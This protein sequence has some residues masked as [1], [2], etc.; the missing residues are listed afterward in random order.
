MSWQCITLTHNDIM[1][2]KWAPIQDLFEEIF[3]RLGAPKS[4]AMFCRD[5]V[6]GGVSLIFSPK[7]SEIITILLSASGSK[8]CERPLAKGTTLLVGNGDP[9]RELL[10]P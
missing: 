9:V 8:P 1:S 4:A 5:E 3:F 7:A 2:G 6:D 10:G